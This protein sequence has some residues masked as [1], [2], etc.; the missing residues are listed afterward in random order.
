MLK[1]SREIRKYPFV[2]V[3]QR[4][5]QYFLVQ[6]FS[7]S[8]SDVFGKVFFSLLVFRLSEYKLNIL[9][10]YFSLD[11]ANFWLTAEKF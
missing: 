7:N 5:F 6:N 10:K 1:N 8:I 4:T 11:F 2:Q 3:I 9:K